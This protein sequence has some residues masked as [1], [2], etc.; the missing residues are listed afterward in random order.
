V[1][2]GAPAVWSRLALPT[3][4]IRPAATARCTQCHD[5]VPVRDGHLA[6]HYAVG[7][8][9]CSASSTPAPT[10]PGGS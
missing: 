8:E 10:D 7:R 2:R 6:G 4:Q 9:L 1:T 3:R 5:L